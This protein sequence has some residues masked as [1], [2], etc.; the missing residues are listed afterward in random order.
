MTLRLLGLTHLVYNRGSV[1]QELTLWSKIHFSMALS[2]MSPPLGY[3]VCGVIG[4]GLIGS[5]AVYQ[6]C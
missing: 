2:L 5:E 3:V 4:W 6:V 1:M